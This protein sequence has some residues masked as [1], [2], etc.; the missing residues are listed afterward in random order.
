MRTEYPE[1]YILNVCLLAVLGQCDS[2]FEE[3]IAHI[4]H[5]QILVYIDFLR[6]S[7]PER[8]FGPPVISPPRE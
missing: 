4:P 5:C 1:E 3:N 6:S 8:M 2:K 7:Q